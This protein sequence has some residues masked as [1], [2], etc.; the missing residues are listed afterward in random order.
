LAQI[1]VDLSACTDIGSVPDI[2]TE[3]DHAYAAALKICEKRV[4][5]LEAILAEMNAKNSF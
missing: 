2:Q 5:E 3:I 4:S 1:V